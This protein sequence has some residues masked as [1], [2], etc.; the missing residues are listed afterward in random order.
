LMQGRP[1]KEAF[2]ISTIMP[3]KLKIDLAYCQDIRFFNDL[4]LIF[5]TVTQLAIRTNGL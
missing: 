5:G 3:A 2:Y 1:D 4:R